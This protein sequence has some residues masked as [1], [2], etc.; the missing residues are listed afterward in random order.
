MGKGKEFVAVVGISG[1]L[2][3]S[4]N[5]AV[6]KAQEKIAGISPKAIKAAAAVSGIATAAFA[7]AK[8]L[9]N[10][11][12]D[13]Q[14]SMN[15]LQASTGATEKEMQQMGE[16]VK[17]IY[18][19]NF[20]A[21]IQDV[22]D[23]VGEIARQSGLSGDA[24]EKLTTGA[25][26]L[27]DTLGYDVQEST[28][29]AKAMMTNFGISGEKAMSLIA[30]GT[31]NGLNYSGE[32]LDSVS[33]YSVQ[34]KKM[35]LSAD[36]MFHIFQKGADS[37]AWNLDKIGDAVKENAIRTIDLSE[38]SRSAFKS[39]GLNVDDIEK[40][41]G[42]GGETASQAFK[43]VLVG[44]SAIEDPLKQNE[45][46][47]QL[48]GT[49]WEDLSAD[50]VMAMGDIS[51]KAYDTNGALE[52]MKE[53][54]YDDLASAMQG[55]WRTIEV[56]LLPAASKLANK[57]N[58]YTPEIKSAVTWIMDHMNILI[59]IIGSVGAAL[60]GLKLARLATEA[61]GY[62]K[63]LKNLA[64]F[65]RKDKDLT[66]TLTA[67]YGKETGARRKGRL[68]T[69]LQTAATNLF[70]K[71]KMKERLQMMK[72]IAIQGKERVAKLRGA[73]AAKIGTAAT[74][75]W[76]KTTRIAAGA[77]KLLGTALNF[78][79]GP[80]GIVILAITALIAAGV[81][82][83]K[84][85]DKVKAKAIAVAAKVKA[86]FVSMKEKIVE[87]FGTI[88]SKIGAALS[89]LAKIVKSPINAV[90]SIINKL[91][92]TVNNLSFDIPDWVPEIG[93]DKIGFNIPKIPMLETGG[94]TNGPSIA[95]EG[96]YREMVIS[97][98]PRYRSENIAYW[99]K[100]GRMLGMENENYSLNT[101]TAVNMQMGGITY[102]PTVKITG[103]ASKS[104]ILQA[105]RQDRE[106][107]MDLIEEW[108]QEKMEFAYE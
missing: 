28:R 19:N 100:A 82:L 71:E 60:G 90:I 7:A 75:I 21:D 1:V 92:D 15:Q 30:A 49:M 54:K 87:A 17:N 88:K 62:A 42:A 80:V 50:V 9:A 63:K 64:V 22:A 11:G 106:E 20:G 83:Y 85:W 23:S 33:E 81:L 96:R 44:I 32:L 93:G 41:F 13:Y 36:E 104:D 99:Q 3:K 25:L 39:I 68:A 84:N 58:E 59:P 37:G 38:T 12:I 72:N 65:K 103:N 31:Q 14:K 34:F 53:Q 97:P 5:A 18:G 24:L 108:W 95:G 57:L 27:R 8:E 52:K 35:G 101:P 40:K 79:K 51:D 69:K 105:L 6:D 48:F 46:G 67:L 77:T 56:A 91:I 70:S 73:A 43:E 94:M 76:G 26:T 10:T 29:A 4:L 107:F 55:I 45:V 98:D 47:V 78:M 2:D 89:G 102:S 16:V 74:A 66:K 61:G 86:V